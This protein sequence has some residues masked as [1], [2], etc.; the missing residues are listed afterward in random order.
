MIIPK[1][2]RFQA[3]SI[4]VAINGFT[5][6]VAHNELCV[7]ISQYVR[8]VLSGSIV[9]IE[10][11]GGSVIGVMGDAIFG[12][13]DSSESVFHS[14]IKIAKDL[15]NLC[16]YLAGT[17]YEESVPSL[18]SLK[19]GVELGTLDVSTIETD[20][21]GTIPFC[22]GPATNYAARILGAGKGNRCHIGPNAFYAGLNAYIGEDQMR[23]VCGKA[24][25]PTYQYWQLDL[26][27]IWI[28]GDPED[29]TMYW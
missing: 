10:E 1:S 9:S 13:L 25:E 29:G 16:E 18:P 17:D 5:G 4:I 21:L 11:S 2:G 23:E 14:C 20:A 8:D 12:I 22:L 24:G 15:N 26:S 3:Y 6:L 27:D 19:I 28:E 7:G